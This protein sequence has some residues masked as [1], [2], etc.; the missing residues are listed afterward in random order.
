[1]IESRK[2]QLNSKSKS[3]RKKTSKINECEYDVFGC[4]FEIVEP[5]KKGFEEMDE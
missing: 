1:M 3:F 4:L 2:T 5:K